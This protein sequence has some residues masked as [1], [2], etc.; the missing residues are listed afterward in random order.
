MQLHGNDNDDGFE[1]TLV[2]PAH[3]FFRLEDE[4]A[5]IAY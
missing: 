2:F 3:R 1:V 5:Y 4:R